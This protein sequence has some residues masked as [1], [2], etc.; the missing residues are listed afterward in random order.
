[1][2]I[3]PLC[4]HLQKGFV[5]FQTTSCETRRML[6]NTC[7]WDCVSCV[8]HIGINENRD[9]PHTFRFGIFHAWKDS[10][11]LLKWCSLERTAFLMSRAWPLA[12][13]ADNV[14]KA[15]FRSILSPRFPDKAHKAQKEYAATALKSCGC[16]WTL[17]HIAG[18]VLTPYCLP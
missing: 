9:C 5:P 16:C 1:M 6:T 14:R 15:K 12:P 2:H 18:P 7:G 3:Y 11:F 13:V 4:Y 8:S 17:L 10:Y